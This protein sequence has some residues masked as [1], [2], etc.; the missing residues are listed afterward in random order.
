MLWRNVN[1]IYQIYPRSFYDASGDG[2]G[3]LP[4]II[5][6]LDY[7]KGGEDSLGVDAIWISP[8]FTSPMADFGYDVADYRD[9]DSLFG[10]MDDFDR[11]IKEA[12]RRDIKVMVDYVP[13]HTSDKHDWF[14][15]SRSSRDNPKRDWYVWRDPAPDGSAP[16]NWLSVFGGSAWEFDERTGQYY[17]HS[18]L[19]EQPDLNWSNPDVRRAM[20]DVV[21][22][23][24]SRGVDGIR[25]DAVRW[26]AKDPEFRDNPQNPD[27]VPGR[28]DPY[29]SQLQSNSRYGQSLFDY[30]AEIAAAVEEFDDR[31]IL[32][33]DYPD[34]NFNIPDQYRAFYNVNPRVAAPFN[35]E[36]FTVEYDAADFRRF[37]GSFQKIIG[38]ELRPFYCF[39]NH[40]KPRL[41]SRVGKEE[42]R[43]IGMMQ[44]TLPGIP[45]IY[46]GEEIGMENVEIP[47]DSVQDPFEKQT[48]NMGLGRDPSRTPM[49]WSDAPQ[50]GFSDVAPWLPVSTDYKTCNVAVQQ[51][52]DSSMFV[53]YKS[54]LDLRR[55][56]VI[57]VGEY[58]GW[59]SQHEQIFGYIR[60]HK[61]EQILTVLNMSDKPLTCVADMRGEV[62]YST[63]PFVTICEHLNVDLEPHQGVIVRLSH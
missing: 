56:A 13:N 43:L 28:D 37:V 27:F 61:D 7:I 29:H 45:V 15:Q 11:L 51:G 6:K 12:H 5:A 25:A 22:F 47:A 34:S 30:L 23:W 4:G 44:L 54:L 48:P 32:F 49:Q 10:D 19:R 46:Y 52:S 53:M 1:A 59:D 39:G 9:V 17:L 8:F 41:A 20:T 40:D 35:F 42:A 24:L 33:E 18:F 3:D 2:V 21:R 36:G 58:V 62:L 63:H 57:R 16:N 31:I 14:E 60:R 50:S 55:S 26:M 38:S